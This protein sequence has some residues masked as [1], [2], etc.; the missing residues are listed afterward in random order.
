MTRRRLLREF[1]RRQSRALVCRDAFG[2]AL[3]REHRRATRATN[4]DAKPRDERVRLGGAA[5]LPAPHE[6]GGVVERHVLHRGEVVR[7]SDPT[8]VARG[9]VHEVRLEQRRLSRGGGGGGELQL[10]AISARIG[11]G[12]HRRRRRRRSLARHRAGD[13]RAKRVHH[14]GE[15]IRG[16]VVRRA[17]LRGVRHARQE[18]VKRLVHHRELS[19]GVRT[20]GGDGRGGWRG[21]SRA[22]RVPARRGVGGGGAR[23]P[24]RRGVR[25]RALCLIQRHRLGADGGPPVPRFFFFARLAFV[26]DRLGVVFVVFVFN[27]EA[28]HRRRRAFE[29]SLRRAAFPLAAALLRCVVAEKHAEFAVCLVVDVLLV[30]IGSRLEVPLHGVAARRRRRRRRKHATHPVQRLEHPARRAE[31]LRVRLDVSPQ[32]HR[33]VRGLEIRH[34]PRRAS[35]LLAAVSIQRR[36][37]LHAKHAV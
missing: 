26:F 30:E 28:F 18:T 12:R 7:Q 17:I 36:A 20:R 9:I 4:R 24:A 29:R 23:V 16:D 8:L 32:F 37:D 34:K 13:T 31:R 22:T 19:R 6:P 2:R 1:V 11:V 27:H 21:V 14:R 5:P 25:R 35:A 10:R 3:G 15:R 33:G